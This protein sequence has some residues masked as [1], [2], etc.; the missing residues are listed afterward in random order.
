M[1]TYEHFEECLAIH[2]GIARQFG[3]YKLSLHSG[4]DKFS[5][6]PIF[7][8]ET[9]GLA[10][11]KTAGTS[12]LEALRTIAAIDPDC[13]LEIYSFAREHFETDRQSYHLSANLNK[14]PSPSEVHDAVG[15][16]DQFDARQILH[17]TFGSVLT[18]Q[19]SDGRKR[20]Y[21]TIMSLMRQNREAYFGNLERHFKRHLQP[22]RY[23]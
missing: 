8:E 21:D 14:A 10:H 22:F 11:L 16:F 9:R 1:G 6:Y 23:I 3:P 13:F 17:V 12:Y 20:F 4:S 19:T 18:E 2:A 15:L 7:M 5:I